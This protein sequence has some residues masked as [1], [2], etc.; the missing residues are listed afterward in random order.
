MISIRKARIWTNIKKAQRKALEI[1]K[2]ICNEIDRRLGLRLN[3]SKCEL[4]K[5]MDYIGVSYKEINN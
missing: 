3:E 5:V 1:F 2:K 4:K